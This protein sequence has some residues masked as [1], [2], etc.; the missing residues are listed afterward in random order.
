M[1]RRNKNVSAFWGGQN[2]P[3]KLCGD[4]Y[5][6]AS[7][8]LEKLGLGGWNLQAVSCLNMNWKSPFQAEPRQLLETPADSDLQ[9]ISGVWVHVVQQCALHTAV[10]FRGETH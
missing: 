6:R 4:L 7:T 9:M 5:F 10:L 3:K 2:L 8:C 1:R